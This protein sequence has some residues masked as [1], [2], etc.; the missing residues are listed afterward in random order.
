[1]TTSKHVSGT[2][3]YV[4]KHITKQGTCNGRYAVCNLANYLRR[5]VP[6]YSQMYERIKNRK[7]PRKGHWV[8]VVAVARDFVTN[9]LY[10]M[11]TNQR[12]FF[13]EVDD[14][15]RYRQ[16]QRQAAA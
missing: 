1:L 11:L 12:P 9:I 8:A 14:Y 16:Q 15:R 6:K 7:P 4:S 3:L 2:T 13:V 10:D 5:T